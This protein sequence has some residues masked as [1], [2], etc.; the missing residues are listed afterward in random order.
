VESGLVTNRIGV[1]GGTFDPPHIA[2]LIIADDARE[3]L[4]LSRIV[5]LPAFVP[6]HKS[7]QQLSAFHDRVEMVRAATDDNELFE[8]STL[9]GD[10]NP[11]SYTVQTLSHMRKQLHP[12]AELHL[13]IGS[14]S[15]IELDSWH[16][17][18]RIVSYAKLVIYPRPGFP[19]K[20]PAWIDSDRIVI[21]E[22]PEL[23]ISSTILRQRV[24]DGRSIRYFVPEA[25][26]Q[27]I[28]RKGLYK[29]AN[30]GVRISSQSEGTHGERAL[31][32]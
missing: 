3:R 16:E 12:N 19:L 5:F 1:F 10:L 31:H 29:T 4:S 7:D 28:S 8:V 6:P 2:H 23:Q 14:D 30:I 21:L 18:R 9:E 24:R 25:V 13:I 11:P 26:F 20:P 17:P 27:L 22:S 15:L 32:S